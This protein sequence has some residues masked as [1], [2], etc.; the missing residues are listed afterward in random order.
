MMF[1][2]YLSIGMMGYAIDLGGYVLLL[3]LHWSLLG[4]IGASIL[5]KIS[6]SVVSFMAHRCFTFRVSHQR[7]QQALRYFT[8]VFLNTQFT[9]V[10]LMLYLLWITDPI[11]AKLAADITGVFLSYWLSKQFVFTH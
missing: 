11:K 8:L 1:L 3:S 10:L 6:S 9:I 7:T 4:P 5:S 2:R